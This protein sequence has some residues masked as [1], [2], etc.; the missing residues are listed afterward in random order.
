MTCLSYGGVAVRNQF[1]GEAES[2]V[3]AR[4]IGQIHYHGE[5]RAEA[6]CQVPVTTVYFTDREGPFADLD[7]W[8][9]DTT[10]PRVAIIRG[11]PGSGRTTFANRWV[12][13]H[14]KDYP[15]G[16]FFVRLASGPN[17]PDRE[18][19]ALREL[20]LATGHRPD[21]IPDSLDG[22]A[23]WWRSWTRGKRIALVI[24]DA[25]TVSQVRSLLPGSGG[26]AVLVT[27]AGS[28]G[29][30]RASAPATFI[31]LVRMPDTAAR[32]LLGQLAGTGRL[33]EDPDIIKRLISICDGSTIALCVVGTM[34]AERP[35]SWLAAKLSRDERILRELSKNE[36]LSVTVVFDAA[37]ERLPE[38]ARACY[39]ALGAH[40]GT[41]DVGPDAVAAVVGMPAEDAIEAL[42]ALETARLVTESHGR[43]LM[44]GLVRRHARTKAAEPDKLVRNFLGY[45]LTFV[46][47]A[48]K[49]LQPNRVWHRTMLPT[50]RVP[51][52]PVEQWLDDEAVNLRAAVEEAYRLGELEQVCQFAIALWAYYERGGHT[53]DLAAVSELG[54][55][56][57]K[58]RGDQL[59]ESVLGAQFGF[60]HLQRGAAMQAIEA[61]TRATHV[62]NAEAE[63]TAVETLGLA[64]L[65]NGEPEVAEGVL[66]RNL[67]LARGIG[68]GR[69]SALAR[70]HLA[71]VAPRDEVPSLLDEAAAGLRG[72]PYNL[73]KI[74]LWRGRRLHDE[75]ALRRVL[76]QGKPRER[77]EAFM[78]LAELSEGDTARQ[79]LTEA[80]EIFR[81]RGLT[82]LTVEAET[83]LAGRD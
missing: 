75:A 26:S 61:S 76:A 36:S 62:G 60:A 77:G 68:D 31:D 41:G 20:L 3:M 53:Q 82:E 51:E 58:A 73:A 18:R 32:E 33:A 35:A 38:P 46:S 80:L 67:Q 14:K 65:A 79:H 72:E 52:F 54:I 50:V 5:R 83:R 70:L 28:L 13:Q 66:R 10:G 29:A 74:D 45:Y 47:A 40:P 81:E 42:E 4:D 34:L 25:L 78:Q 24:D 23:G 8:F 11:E 69:R 30:L 9:S 55:E 71:K 6:L 37:Y 57:S 48:A 7:S 49:T 39:E 12:E 27:A 59:A 64:H 15:D 16:Q 2:L 44:S 21:E 19:S 43:F 17:G 22:R 56:A 63:A 1:D